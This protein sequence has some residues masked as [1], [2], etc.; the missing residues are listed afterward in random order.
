MTRDDG[1]ALQEII[2]AS[3]AVARGDAAIA[4]S[5]VRDWMRSGELEALGA[6]YHLL[7]A[8]QRRPQI[9][10]PLEFDDYHQFLMRYYERCIREDPK[11]K[12]ADSRYSAGWDL[13]N[14]LTSVW[15]EGRTEAFS[16]WKR[17]LEDLYKSG[18]SDV[19]EC[20]VNA[21]LEHLFEN[22]RLAKEFSGWKDD[23]LLGD[24]YRA[25]LE[26]SARG[27]ESPLG[28]GKRPREKKEPS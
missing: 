12:W 7:M 13:V 8:G 9:E 1:G 15:K 18:D 19:R 24:A 17:W 16:E 21:T 4:G 6:L 22:R 26:W 14:W 23:P 11:S 3:E 2:A 25:A 10:P 28:S 27:G 20:L 5:R